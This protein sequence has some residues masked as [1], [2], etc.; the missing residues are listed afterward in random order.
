MKVSVYISYGLFRDESLNCFH[1]SYIKLFLIKME[2]YIHYYY[3]YFA[4]S[5]YLYFEIKHSFR[6]E[7]Q[8][9]FNIAVFSCFLIEYLFKT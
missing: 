6:E 3:E 8:L 1:T 9:C 2:Y 5:L 4:L 7:L